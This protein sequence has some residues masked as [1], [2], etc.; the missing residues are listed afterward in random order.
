MFTMKSGLTKS[1]AHP[2][3]VGVVTQALRALGH[4][5]HADKNLDP[6][7]DGDLYGALTKF[8]IA[9]GLPA[10][11]EMRRMDSTHRKMKAVLSS[12][13]TQS[14]VFARHRGDYE[15]HLDVVE[16]GEDRREYDGYE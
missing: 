11:G 1:Y 15:D 4:Y 3:D 8:Q 9:H 13:P 5:D 12:N 2:D 6:L 16:W 7:A 14:E 10:T